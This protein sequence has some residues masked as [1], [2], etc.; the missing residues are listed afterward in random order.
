MEY[1][2]QLQKEIAAIGE[3]MVVCGEDCEGIQRN[4]IDG[5]LPRCLILETESR[6]KSGG[7]IVCGIN[8]A[9]APPREVQFYR[10]N[11]ISYQS[12]LRWLEEY[13]LKDIP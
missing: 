4:Q 7:S 8:P 1:L 10:K 9:P 6:S 3:R 11:G 2:K 5:I 13:K 12:L